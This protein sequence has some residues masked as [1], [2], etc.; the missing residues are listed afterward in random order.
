MDG[1]KNGRDYW[2]STWVY[3]QPCM[4]ILEIHPFSKCSLLP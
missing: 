3:I 1:G 4:A 2:Y